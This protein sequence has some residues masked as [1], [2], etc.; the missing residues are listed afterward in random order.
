[1]APGVGAVASLAPRRLAVTRRSHADHR[2]GG[3][4]IGATAG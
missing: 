2:A 4:S 1:M 3:G